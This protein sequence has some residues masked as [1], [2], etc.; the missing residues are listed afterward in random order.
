MFLTIISVSVCEHDE[1]NSVT[2]SLIYP[3]TLKEKSELTWKLSCNHCAA[4]TGNMN[5]KGPT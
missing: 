5:P 1:Y 2:L 4:I 3:E